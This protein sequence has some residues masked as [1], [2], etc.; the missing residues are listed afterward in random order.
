MWNELFIYLL[1]KGDI[2]IGYLTESAIALALF[3]VPYTLLLRKEHIFRQN[4]LTLVAILALSLLLPFCNFHSLYPSELLERMSSPE[5][6][7]IVEPQSMGFSAAEPVVVSISYTPG[8]V[9]LTEPERSTIS[10]LE[11][12]QSVG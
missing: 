11:V 5:P 10:P 8:H 2:L 3:Y 4:R 9:A 12:C 1:G 7:P 6:A